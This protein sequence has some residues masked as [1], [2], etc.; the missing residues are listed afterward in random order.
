M[1]RTRPTL[2]TLAL[3]ALSGCATGGATPAADPFA[4]GGS[5]RQFVQI[6]VMNNNFADAPLWAVV[7][8]SRPIRLGNV[9]GKTESRFNLPWRFS[10][11]L[12]LEIDMVAGPRCLTRPITVDP[13]DV[14]L[15]EIQSVFRETAYCER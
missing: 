12:R 8:A 11:P 13:G 2:L 15:L 1:N 10:L 5:E 4:A 7:Q 6:D 14:L 3:I 9:T